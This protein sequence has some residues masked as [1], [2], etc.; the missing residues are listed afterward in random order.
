MALAVASGR[1]GNQANVTD[2]GLLQPA[3]GAHDRAV[4][5]RLVATDKDLGL[6]ALVATGGNDLGHGVGHVRQGHG[7][8]H[9]FVGI[10]LAAK[11]PVV[12]LV[13]L[14]RDGKDLDVVVLRQGFAGNL[15]Q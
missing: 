15:G 1:L 9:L 2:T 4:I 10:D 12:G 14:D 11:V 5:D 8:V 3:H 6:L 13:G 7:L